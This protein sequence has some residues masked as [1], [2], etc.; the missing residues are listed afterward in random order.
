MTPRERDLVGQ[1]QFYHDEAAMLSRQLHNDRFGVSR[2]F[3]PLGKAAGDALE[4]LP[5]LLQPDLIML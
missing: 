2:Q 5:R 3:H 1:A 4:C